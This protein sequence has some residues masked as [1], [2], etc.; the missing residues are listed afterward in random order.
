M[1]YNRKRPALDDCP[2]EAVLAIVS[3]K[4]KVRVL[5]LLS[6]DD[7]TF[8]EVRCSV[9]DVSQQVLSS[10]LK[11]L[12][13]NGAVRRSGIVSPRQIRYGLTAKGRELVAL[14]MPLA[15]WGSKLLGQSGA[16]WKPPEIRRRPQRED[17]RLGA[18]PG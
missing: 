7:L 10:V 1:T 3:G 6:L 13:G 16:N 4:W 11:E 8:S 12:I 18:L 15:E 14:L 17:R 5:Y 9:G 2:V